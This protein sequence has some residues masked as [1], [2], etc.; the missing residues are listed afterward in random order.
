[1]CLTSEARVFCVLVFEIA[2]ALPGAQEHNQVV[3]SQ[4][5]VHDGGKVALGEC[6]ESFAGEKGRAVAGFRVKEGVCKQGGRRGDINV[7]IRRGSGRKRSHK[8]KKG[9]ALTAAEL[10]RSAHAELLSIRNCSICAYS[11][12]RASQ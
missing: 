3:R 8:P 11:I 1:M 9:K 10:F 12:A 4:S 6:R 5:F 7:K 2:A